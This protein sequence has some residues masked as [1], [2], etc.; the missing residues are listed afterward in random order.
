MVL[1]NAHTGEKAKSVFVYALAGTPEI[2]A[3]VDRIMAHDY[4]DRGLDGDAARKLQ[5]Q[6]T[7]KLKYFIDGPH[8][9]KLCKR[10]T[11]GA[12]SPRH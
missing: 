11:Y 3:E 6:F 2:V 5:D 4:P 1:N 10:A 8:A 9:D 12:G 7:A